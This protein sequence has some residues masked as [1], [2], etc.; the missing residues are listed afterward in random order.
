VSLA[1]IGLC[2]VDRHWF[3]FHERK[4]AKPLRRKEEDIYVNASCPVAT[5]STCHHASFS[6]LDGLDSRL[7]TYFVTVHGPRG[8]FAVIVAFRSAKVAASLQEPRYFRGAKGDKRSP[9]TVTL[10]L[11][12]FATWRLGVKEPRLG[13][14]PM[15]TKLVRSRERRSLVCLLVNGLA[16][17]QI[18]NKSPPPDRGDPHPTQ[19]NDLESGHQHNPTSCLPSWSATGDIS[20]SVTASSSSHHSSACPDRQRGALRQPLGVR[21]ICGILQPFVHR[22]SHPVCRNAASNTCPLTGFHFQ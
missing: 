4:G 19:P 1:R 15:P 3:G 8:R 21:D 20:T 9:R 12:D 22:R 5:I 17:F 14:S 2:T 18:R 6:G 11:C 7:S 10:F 16:Y 13:P